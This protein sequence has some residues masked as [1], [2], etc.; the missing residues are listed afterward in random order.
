M[1]SMVT[2]DNGKTE[3]WI[4]STVPILARFIG[5]Q[6]EREIRAAEHANDNTPTKE[7]GENP[8]PDFFSLPVWT[9]QLRTQIQNRPCLD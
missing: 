3:T 4:E 2:S 6:I 9:Q 8:G 5:G 1:C 7:A